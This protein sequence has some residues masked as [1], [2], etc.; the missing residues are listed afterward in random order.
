MDTVLTKR[1]FPLLQ[2]TATNVDIAIV[3]PK[4]HLLTDEE[5]QEVIDRL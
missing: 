5:I 3:A 2:V 1:F 4:F